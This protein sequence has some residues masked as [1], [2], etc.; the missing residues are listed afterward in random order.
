MINPG[1][2]QQDARK[3]S[4][5]GMTT[6]HHGPTRYCGS[7][8]FRFGR[9]AA[10]SV[11]HIENVHWMRSLGGDG[12][13]P[14]H[15]GRTSGSGPVSAQQRQPGGP[16]ELGV[17]AVIGH[18]PNGKSMTGRAVTQSNKERTGWSPSGRSESLG[19]RSGDGRA[20]KRLCGSGNVRGGPGPAGR[21][22]VRGG[23]FSSTSIAGCTRILDCHGARSS[24]PVPVGVLQPENSVKFDSDLGDLSLTSTGAKVGPS[25]P[26]SWQSAAQM[27]FVAVFSSDRGVFM[28]CR[29][30]LIL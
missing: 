9:R 20:Q 23:R 16:N 1:N 12:R 24:T 14:A 19:V 7:H 29:C 5:G 27:Q 30:C 6:L 8:G 4:I 13:C 10:N 17:G 15:G 2:A 25:C 18:R 26:A 3:S 22:S 21:N 11:S 28:S